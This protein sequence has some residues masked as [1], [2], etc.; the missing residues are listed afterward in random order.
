MDDWTDVEL[1][2]R[3][4][5]SPDSAGDSVA[6]V[7]SVDGKRWTGWVGDERLSTGDLGDFET[8]EDAM[9]VADAVLASLGE[10]AAS[11]QNPD[12][13]VADGGDDGEH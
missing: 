8:I 6:L 10:G 2:L 1:K 9:E 11:A 5:P 13:G 7:M 4:Q 3:T 12:S